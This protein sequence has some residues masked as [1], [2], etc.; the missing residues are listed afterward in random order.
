LIVS[1]LYD[2]VREGKL[3]EL[4][5]D[6]HNANKGTERGSYM[7][8]QSVSKL[9]MG[10]SFVVDRNGFVIAGNKTQLAALDSGLDDVII[11]QTDG[12]KGVV[13]QRTDLDLLTDAKAK[14]LAIA[15]NRASEVSLQWD[16]EV[17]KE[18]GEEVELSDWFMPDEVGSWG[19]EPGDDS[20]DDEPEFT[21]REQ[22]PKEVSCTC[23]NCGHQFIQQ[24]H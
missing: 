21:D 15:D 19:S 10:R 17:L 1:E 5:P 23:P 22:S 3:T 2:A 18:I 20:Y 8:A 6:P 11:V 12:T 13:V 7:V 9:G 16:T 24:H 14:E 4:Q